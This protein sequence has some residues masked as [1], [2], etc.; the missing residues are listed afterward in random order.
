MG[1]VG[2]GEGGWEGV[3]RKVPA[4]LLLFWKSPVRQNIRAEKPPGGSTA[5]EVFQN[6]TSL[7]LK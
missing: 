7:Q 1:R 6:A 4:M 2:E 3:E 5:L